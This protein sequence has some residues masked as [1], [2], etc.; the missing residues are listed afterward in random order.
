[1]T[2]EAKLDAP[3]R[4][5][6]SASVVAAKLIAE[7]TS[8]NAV[9]TTTYLTTESVAVIDFPY[10]SSEFNWRIYYRAGKVAN[11]YWFSQSIDFLFV[12]FQQLLSMQP[13]HTILLI[14]LTGQ[15]T[16]PTMTLTPPRCV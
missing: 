14:I 1:M 7:K 4:I 11:F 15:S 16:M 12:F 2:I 9:G 13:N 6:D 5:Y 10:A 3:L 8:S